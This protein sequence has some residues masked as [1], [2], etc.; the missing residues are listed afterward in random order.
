MGPIKLRGQDSTAD[1]AWEYGRVRA[2]G[3]LYYSY[4]THAHIANL[5]SANIDVETAQAHEREAVDKLA[6]HDVTKP[7]RTKG[8]KVPW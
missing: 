6:A 3:T 7:V 1:I 4:M 2:D 5:R 8:G